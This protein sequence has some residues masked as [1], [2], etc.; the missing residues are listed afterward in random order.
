MSIYP[1][2]GNWYAVENEYL[3]HNKQI[4]NANVIYGFLKR[5]FDAADAAIAGVLGN[6]QLES[7]LNP[8][9]WQGGSTP[10]DWRSSSKGFG[11]SQ[12]SP[13]RLYINW[14]GG[15]AYATGNWSSQLRMWEYEATHP[16]LH[17]GTINEWLVWSGAAAGDMYHC[18]PLQFLAG[19]N[20]ATGE[21]DLT[22]A[23]CAMIWMHNYLRPAAAGELP[24]TRQGYATSWYNW[25][26]G[27][28]PEPVLPAFNTATLISVWKSCIMKK[29]QKARVPRR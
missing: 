1:P 11:L 13:G 10:A 23:D 27:G 18:L 6:C 7:T 28:G 17:D 5:R 20:A 26:I 25:I 22:A 4:I 19:Y 3:D 14:A 24:A 15:D 16:N 29:A 2:D 8:Y 12:W 21:N 9:M